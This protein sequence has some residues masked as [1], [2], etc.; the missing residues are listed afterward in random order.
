LICVNDPNFDDEDDRATT[1]GSPMRCLVAYYS[2]A[3]TTR[4]LAERVSQELGADLAEVRSPR[5]R[6]GLLVYLLGSSDSWR[7]RLPRIEVSGAPPE[8]YDFVLVMA[9]VWAGHASTPIRAYLAENRDKFKRAGF[10]LTCANWCSPGAFEEMTE[11]SGVKPE[12]ALSL[13]ER[14]IKSSAYMPG[15]LTS[16]LAS[17]KLGQAA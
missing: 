3:G 16:V 7:G 4:K 6:P 2:L 15:A 1:R 9:P 10:V 17:L 12:I 13:R 8:S 5:Y 11:L 14:E